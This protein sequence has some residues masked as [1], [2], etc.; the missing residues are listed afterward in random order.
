VII[1]A[2]PL[3]P[4]LPFFPDNI[5]ESQMVPDRLPCRARSRVGGEHINHAP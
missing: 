4:V 2:L 5:G 3:V 1:G